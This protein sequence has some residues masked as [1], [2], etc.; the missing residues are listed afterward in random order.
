[1]TKSRFGAIPPANGSKG[2]SG[3][4][5]MVWLVDILYIWGGFGGGV[6]DFSNRSFLECC[7]TS[8]RG[9]YF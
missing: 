2:L 4:L 9:V 7:D 5:G 6:P 1:M 3:C 8:L